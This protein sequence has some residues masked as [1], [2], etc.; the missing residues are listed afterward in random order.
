GRREKFDAGVAYRAAASAARALSGKPRATVAYFLDDGQDAART[1]A[2][3]TGAIVGCQG[4][5]LFRTEKNR[6]PFTRLLWSNGD[7][8]AIERGQIL[9][10]SVNLTR[11]LVNAPA[12]EVYPETFAQRAAEVAKQRGL[13]CEIW[14]ESRLAEERCGSLLGVAK[15]STR[16]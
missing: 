4:Q 1:E 12:D 9:G 15:G 14:D 11:R 16:P 10:D 2:A 13:E 8:Q 7:R 6:H 3:V 5:D